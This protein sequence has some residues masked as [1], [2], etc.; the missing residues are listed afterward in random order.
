MTDTEIDGTAAF[1]ATSASD[2]AAQDAPPPV[3]SD[4]ILAA[5]NGDVDAAGRAIT[6]NSALVWSIV[7]RFAGRGA[8]SEDLYQI[9]C[10][11]F[12]KAL[13]SFD[14]SLGLHFST[15]AVP[16][17]IGEIRRFLRDDGPVKVSR[18]LKELASKIRFARYTLE[19][20]K[21][22][23]PTV[24]EVAQFVGASPEEVA[25]AESAVS[26]PQSLNAP[27]RVGDSGA[28]GEKE[29]GFLSVI[30]DD[31]SETETIDSI[32]LFT[33]ACELPDRERAVIALRYMRGLTQSDTARVLGISQVQVSRVE[34]KAL[35]LLRE[36][37]E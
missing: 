1:C 18:S 10:I 9:G 16:K 21:G 27:F 15:Y 33:A 14:Q 31:A 4:T 24:S 8:E 30:S 22:R 20:E 7:R 3:I 32:D 23:A 34:K 26:D 5:I 6:E 12:V 29:F 25:E 13:R 35:E 2:S 36:K 28:G 17:I 37:L 11:G 19:Q